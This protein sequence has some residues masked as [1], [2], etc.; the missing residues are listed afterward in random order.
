M[1]CNDHLETNDNSEPTT[2]ANQVVNRNTLWPVPRFPPSTNY[3]INNIIR[4]INYSHKRQMQAQESENNKKMRSS[5]IPTGYSGPSQAT[6]RPFPSSTAS[7]S[8]TKLQ[9]PNTIPENDKKP[10]NSI[11][12][13]AVPMDLSRYPAGHHRPDRDFDNGEAKR[14]RMLALRLPINDGFGA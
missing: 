14:R 8:L 13:T 1:D 6:H 5:S 3:V 9:L 10:T 2:T 12:T 7:K 4:K 11:T